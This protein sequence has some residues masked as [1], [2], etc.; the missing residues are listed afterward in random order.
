MGI[1]FSLPHRPQFKNLNINIGK[2]NPKRNSG[3]KPELSPKA[4][5]L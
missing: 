1:F 4:F 2:K 3:K 5:M